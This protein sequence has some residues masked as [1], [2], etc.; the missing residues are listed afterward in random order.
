MLKPEELEEYE[1]DEGNVFNKKTFEG[2]LNKINFLIHDFIFVD[3]K[4]QG[5]I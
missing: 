1:D 4:R 5:L 2:K 3:L